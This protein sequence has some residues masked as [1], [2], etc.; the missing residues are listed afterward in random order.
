MMFNLDMSLSIYEISQIFKKILNN[1]FLKTFEW[2]VPIA[3]LVTNF[4]DCKAIR[5]R[6][7]KYPMMDGYY[8]SKHKS[9][10]IHNGYIYIHIQ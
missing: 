6:D 3:T 4:S 1:G 2:R 10:I 8:P 9:I 7:G 5:F